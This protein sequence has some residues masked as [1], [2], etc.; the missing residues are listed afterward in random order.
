MT[1]IRAD[2]LVCPACGGDG[3]PIL[4]GRPTEEAQEAA[5]EGSLVL[6]GCLVQGDGSDPQWQCQRDGSHQWTDG[7]EDSPAW[8]A[9][10]RRILADRPHCPLCGSASVLL[11]YEHAADIWADNIADGTAVLTTEDA[12][13]GVNAQH[14]CKACRHTWP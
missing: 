12:P 4:F 1:V 6:A 7:D 8:I 11:V 9:A 2:G 13:P 14:R 10:I 5:R 3:A